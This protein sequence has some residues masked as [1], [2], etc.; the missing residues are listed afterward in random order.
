MFLVDV[1]ERVRTARKAKGLTQ[2]EL[3]ERSGVSRARIDT[4]ENGRPSDIGFGNV[5]RILNGVGLDL[6]ITSSPR[7][8]TL[9]DLM[10]ENEEEERAQ[11]DR[12]KRFRSDVA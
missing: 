9:D 11:A 6:R 8:P 7:R 5:V 10:R 4:L 1:G 2:R 12:S 3:A